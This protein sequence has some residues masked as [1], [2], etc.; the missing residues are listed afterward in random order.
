MSSCAGKGKGGGKAAGMMPN[1]APP[2]GKGGKPA[3]KPAGKKG[4]GG[5]K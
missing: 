3:M 1:M 4:K 5:K 2:F